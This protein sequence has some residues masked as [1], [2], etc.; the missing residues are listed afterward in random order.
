MRDAIPTIGQAVQARLPTTESLTAWLEQVPVRLSQ[1]TTEAAASIGVKLDSARAA[2]ILK[3]EAAPSHA[4][5]SGTAFDLHA[6]ATPSEPSR[7]GPPSTATDVA[8]PDAGSIERHEAPR[9]QAA[10]L[11]LPRIPDSP[12][13][14]GAGSDVILSAVSESLDPLPNRRASKSAAWVDP[15]PA[16]ALILK[17]PPTA[18]ASASIESRPLSIE[19]TVP[20]PVA[21]IEPAER[22][23]SPPRVPPA[24]LSGTSAG[25][26]DP[27]VLPVTHLDTPGSPE[28]GAEPAEAL[29]EKRKDVREWA[30]LRDAVDATRAKEAVS[31][32]IMPALPPPA[33][34]S[35]PVAPSLPQFEPISRPVETILGRVEPIRPQAEPM[36]AAEPAP[37]PVEQT[38]SLVPRAEPVRPDP[39]RPVAPPAP[40]SRLLDAARAPPPMPAPQ[41]VV[42]V[43]SGP[44]TAPNEQRLIERAESLLKMSDISGA[45]LI[46]DRAMAA[47]SARAAF[48]LAQTYDPRVL[49][50]WR[51]VGIK[52]DPAKAQELYARAQAGGIREAGQ[53]RP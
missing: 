29:A 3:P 50:E 47:G 23:A 49:D 43:P 7:T 17:S 39:T 52:G 1:L 53:R 41:V 30:G 12:I 28:P 19:P 22:D 46:L 14:F 31:Q 6:A 13:A 32:A 8:A 48:L 45:R 34:E 26:S 27:P 42:Q 11:I 44:S 16:R 18:D 4:T 36:P 9:A 5:S 10:M 20:G 21:P 51:V 35:Q 33:T 38:V 15:D 25:S 40:M 24:L 37:A 2:P